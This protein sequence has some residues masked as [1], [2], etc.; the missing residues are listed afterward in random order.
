MKSNNHPVALTVV[1][2]AP[3]R[4]SSPG[5]KTDLELRVSAPLNGNNLPVIIF[6]HGFGSNMD[7]Y[8]PLVNYWA[9]RGFAVI[10]PTFLDSRSYAES[11]HA[12]HGEAVQAFLNDPASKH[13]WRQ[14]ITDLKAVLDQLED[15]EESCPGLQGK[16]D[17][18]RV[19]A[20][21]HSFGAHTVAMFLGAR[22][23]LPDGSPVEDFKDERI[24]AGILLSAAG[25][26]DDALSA[27]AKEHFPYLNLDYTYLTTPAL[28]VAGDQDH[29]PLTVLGPDWFT[30]AYLISPGADTL[31]SLFGGE[32]M[33]GGI[34]GHLVRET[35]DEN[36]ER[37][38]LVSEVTLAYLQ[39]ILS[40]NDTLWKK[41]N[42]QLFGA[43]TQVGK[44]N[45]KDS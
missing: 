6:A 32:H 16:L 15:I 42:D 40:P 2:V 39:K 20:A 3:I 4:L 17:K 10:Q 8:A 5:R 14:R 25:R 23:V 29:S 45:L 30:D 28:V 33:L 37:V 27:F 34:S 12:D 18:S 11:H 13:I 36:P 19:A 9:A 38:A 21:G 1:S 31:L 43:G 41:L 35:T 24:K 26:G 44:I 22:T 7:A